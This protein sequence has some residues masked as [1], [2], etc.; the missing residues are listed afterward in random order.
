MGRVA[1]MCSEG[2]SAYRITVAE[3]NSGGN[4]ECMVKVTKLHSEGN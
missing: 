3:V 1:W 2:K 4:A